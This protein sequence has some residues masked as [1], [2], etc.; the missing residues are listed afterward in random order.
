MSEVMNTNSE[1]LT[2]TDEDLDAV[3]GG[4]YFDCTS[5]RNHCAYKGDNAWEQWIADNYN[6]HLFSQAGK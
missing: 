3:T 1:F 5:W 2:L 6:F 4:G